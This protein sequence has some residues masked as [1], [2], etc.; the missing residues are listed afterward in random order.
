M[1][2]ATINEIFALC[3]DMV[4]EIKALRVEVA[5]LKTI[6]KRAPRKKKEEPEAPKAVEPTEDTSSDTALTNAVWERAKLTDPDIPRV[7]VSVRPDGFMIGSTFVP[8]DKINQIA[9]CQG[10]DLDVANE[11][12]VPFHAVC[13]VRVLMEGVK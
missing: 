6:R 10:D 7:P 9:G 2:E 11:C 1:N 12:A 3:K 5:E 8:G 13:A 4:E